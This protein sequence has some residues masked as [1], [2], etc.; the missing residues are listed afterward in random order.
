MVSIEFVWYFSSIVNRGFQHQQLIDFGFIREFNVGKPT[1]IFNH[2]LIMILITFWKTLSLYFVP[3]PHLNIYLA[4][5]QQWGGERR[6]REWRVDRVRGGG[7]SQH[8]TIPS[9]EL[10]QV[11]EDKTGQ[12]RVYTKWK[13]PRNKLTQEIQRKKGAKR[14]SIV[15]D[16]SVDRFCEPG[17]F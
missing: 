3:S 1:I 13:P 16:A 6:R 8:N 17:E 12:D 10:S 2:I 5:G 15:P 14:K 4:A 9:L 7:E 11:V